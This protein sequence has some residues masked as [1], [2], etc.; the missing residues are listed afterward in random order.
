MDQQENY[1]PITRR[2][3]LM[4]LGSLAFLLPGAKALA[5]AAPKAGKW[6]PK[7]EAVIKVEIATQEGFRVHRPYVAVWIEDKEGKSIRTISLWVQTQRRGP[8]WIPDLR[9]W[10][11]AETTR[12]TAEGGDLVAT[13]SSATREAGVYNVVWDG[14]TDKGA[15]VETGEYYVCIEAAREH[16]TYQLIREKLKFSNKA[17]SQQLAGNVEIKGASVELHKRK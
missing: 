14:K 16:G 9:R 4:G 2:T 5:G 7:L 15:L 11:R 8:R 10:Y 6:D 12:A 13:T 3:V 1:S 17:F